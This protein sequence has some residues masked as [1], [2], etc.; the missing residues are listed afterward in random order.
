[1]ADV[2][3]TGP[4][5]PET[6]GASTG[7]E[8]EQQVD[9]AAEHAGQQEGHHDADGLEVARAV[10]ARLR[11]NGRRPSPGRRGSRSPR[12]TTLSGAHPDRRDPAPLGPLVDNLVQ[13]SGWRTDV[14]VHGVFARWAELVGDEVASHC[15]PQG[16]ADATLTV[17]T[18]STA[19]ATQLRLL[20]PTVLRRLNEELGH[21]TVHLIEVVGPQAPSWRRGRR[22]VR[23]GRG[24]RDTYG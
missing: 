18:D 3:N 10:A 24:P 16:F 5:P 15:T 11:A 17:G 23:G 14:A 9:H 2:P 20:A 1:M 7:G 21:E 4:E 8:D 22:A 13:E 19:W 6:P 12:D